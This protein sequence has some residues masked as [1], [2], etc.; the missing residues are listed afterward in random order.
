MTAYVTLDECQIYFTTQRVNSS[1]WHYW[2]ESERQVAI[3]HATALI[4]NLNFVG[5]KG[6]G[7]LEFPRKG[8]TTVPQAIKNACMEIAYSLLDGRD[9]ELDA[10]SIS[11][12]ATV[13]GPG[14]R[15]VDTRTYD[16]AKAHSIPSQM[17][18]RYLL[19]YLNQSN[20]V[21]L[22]RVD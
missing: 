11:D 13:V 20:T 16:A 3:N 5:E 7:E 1:N 15:Q 12:A 18:W 14:K 10:Q 22:S 19:P 6:D 17:A 8:E 21:T 2:P 9:I 4:G